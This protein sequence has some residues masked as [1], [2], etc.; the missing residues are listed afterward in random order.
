[1]LGEFSDNK[2]QDAMGKK[3][4]RKRIASLSKRVAEHE[5]KIMREKAKEI[6]IMV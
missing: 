6:Q 2:R 1:M 3:S 5:L 4:L